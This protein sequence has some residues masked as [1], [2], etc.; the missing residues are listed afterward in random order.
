[1]SR[2]PL[3]VATA[4]LAFFTATA[5]AQQPAQL[6]VSLSVPPAD[7]RVWMQKLVNPAML[8]IW[9]VSNAAI[10]DEGTLD[11]AQL[12]DAEWVQ[13]ERQARMLAA[14]GKDL[15]A[16]PG[17]V[18]A[19]P[20]NA[21]VAEGEVTM[22]AVQ[23]HIDRDPDGFREAAHALAEHAGKIELAAKARDAAATGALI[24]E[25]DAV[26]ESC[27]SRYWYPE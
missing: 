17:Y 1:M 2:I 20:E 10:N 11:S 26:C 21:E 8:A 14:A 3:A 5:L 24:G 13:L 16:A 19:F 9:E 7:V 22:A 12:D 25:M 15:A 27:H 6:V 18:A 4:A 23:A